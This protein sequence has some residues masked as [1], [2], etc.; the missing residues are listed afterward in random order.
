MID[1]LAKHTRA[2]FELLGYDLRDP[3]I[4]DSPERIAKYLAEWHTMG[5]DPPKLTVFEDGEE[6]DQMILQTRIPF[7]SLCAHH[8]L[9]FHGV[10]TVG[11]I[12]DKALVGLSKFSRVIDH[13]ANRYS[14]QERVTQQVAD[15]L[16]VQIKPKGLGVVLKAEHH[17]MKCR[18]VK[19]NG[20]PTITDE[21]RGCFK[22]DPATRAEFLTWARQQ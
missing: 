18:G 14:V 11:Y 22:S 13:F 5:E 17:C 6:Y 12:P 20:V 15:Y 3:H 4:K 16:Q 2:I 9:P 1:D 21:L 8:G 19:K 7:D 10:A